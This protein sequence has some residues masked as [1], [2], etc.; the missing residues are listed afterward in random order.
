MKLAITRIPLVAVV[1]CLPPLALSHEMFLKPQAHFA[2]P[3]QALTVTLVNGTFTKSENVTDRDRM[4]DVSVVVNG[5]VTHP[6]AR[7]WS[8]ADKAS[9]L[10][11]SLAD[12]GTHLIGVSTRPRIIELSAKD[13]DAY[14]QHDGV[15]DTLK[16]RQS[17]GT[18]KAPV[19]ER[20]SKHVRTL[21][22][23]GDRRTDDYKQVLGDPVEIIPARNPLDV[24]A[25]EEL[26][27]TVLFKGKPLANQLV[28]V[29]HDGHHGHGDGDGGGHSHAAKLRTAP[30]GTAK[31]KVSQA[32]KWYVTLI[33]MQRVDDGE[34]DYESNWATLT[35]QVR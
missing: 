16:A 24:K 3:S 17:A 32:G 19:K 35:F 11:L 13:F 2:A 33:N 4:A 29:N 30:D 1:L 23:L 26:A 18:S 7:Q 34:V 9:H 22:Q 10:K 31:F 20:Y 6:A 8:D 5:K 15:E 12:A 21:V 28:Y 14:L 27:F 25:G